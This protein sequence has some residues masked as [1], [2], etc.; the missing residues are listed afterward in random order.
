MIFVLEFHRFLSG[1]NQFFKV[2][3]KQYCHV[4]WWHILSNYRTAIC[5]SVHALYLLSLWVDSESTWRG[6]KK[7]VGC[8]GLAYVTGTDTGRG[9]AFHLTWQKAH[10]VTNQMAYSLLFNVSCAICFRSSLRISESFSF[11]YIAL[12]WTFT[13]LALSCIIE[14]NVCVSSSLPSELLSV[15]VSSSVGW[16]AAVRSVD[17]RFQYATDVRIFLLCPTHSVSVRI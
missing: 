12:L 6:R 8:C 11:I 13:Y 17:V 2:Y 3:Y 16:L 15:L 7:G 5:C 1:K 10:S 9:E 4:K 14:T